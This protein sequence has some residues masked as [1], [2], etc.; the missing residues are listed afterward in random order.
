LGADFYS[1]G[2]FRKPLIPRKTWFSAGFGKREMADIK[3]RY[4]KGM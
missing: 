4:N 2:I 3:K 1:F